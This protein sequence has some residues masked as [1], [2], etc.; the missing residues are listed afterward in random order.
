M[1]DELDPRLE[2]RLRAALRAEADALPVMVREQDVLAARRARRT[3][4]FAVPASLLAAAA[5]I[6]LFVAFGG[7]G[8]RTPDTTGAS[9]SPTA[10]G[11]GSRLATFAELRELLPPE[12][13]VLVS[14]DQLPTA[15][16]SSQDYAQVLGSIQARGRIHVAVQCVGAQNIVLEIGDSGN[17]TAL[18]CSAAA[19][20]GEFMGGAGD[21]TITAPG[22]TAYRIIVASLPADDRE[23]ASL[24]ELRTLAA[25][26]GALMDA[27]IGTGERLDAGGALI[28]TTTLGILGGS[29]QIVVAYDCVGGQIEVRVATADIVLT[30]F[31]DPCDSG[32]TAR[33]LALA[34]TDPGARLEVIAIGGVRWR[35]FAAVSGS[36]IGPD[37]S[38]SI[39]TDFGQPG[40][41]IFVWPVGGDPS[42]P[43]ALVVEAWRPGATNATSGVASPVVRRELAQVPLTFLG[44]D[45]RI[46][47]P[48]QARISTTGRLALSVMT[49]GDGPGVVIL[50]L[51]HPDEAPVYVFGV[52]ATDVAFGPDG[53]FASTGNGAQ[54][55]LETTLGTIVTVPAGDGVV[56]SRN[57]APMW[58]A[59]GSGILG[60]LPTRG[61]APLYGV[62]GADGWRE[63][64][65][66]LPKL[67]LATGLERPV[68]GE[69]R[70]LQAS[71][72]NGTCGLVEQVSGGVFAGGAPWTLQGT[73][74]DEP[75][76]AS[77]GRQAWLLI[78]PGT[79]LSLVRQDAAGTITAIIPV[80]NAWRAGSGVPPLILGIL[81]TDPARRVAVVVDG[82]GITWLGADAGGAG[83]TSAEAG[84]Q[85]G[86]AGWGGGAGT[87]PAP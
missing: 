41:A 44:E 38:P 46:M 12:A 40:E 49:P 19:W 86:F 34:T 47:L 70:A 54:I 75:V 71:C 13:D 8:G 50:D 14:G 79:G 84:D 32:P 36:V 87:Y 24:D 39:P 20:T 3:R 57:G 4:R 25:G 64:G 10:A 31:Q 35:L 30:S 42:G 52:L 55:D 60:F 16:D 72:T 85:A 59:D 51:A 11:L 45:S 18:E 33:S 69:G 48:V 15:Q 53:R 17:T 5:A 76:W 43:E 2:A 29:Q 61:G 63:L 83:Y 82:S 21:V 23:L 7:F 81:D 78:T 62:I 6:A 65:N 56:V 28:E 67:S 27:P 73:V 66:D 22:T 1:A 74:L 26:A 58:L 37:P 68:S 77:D 9:P 80:D